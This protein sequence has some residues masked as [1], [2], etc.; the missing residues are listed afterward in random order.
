MTGVVNRYAVGALASERVLPDDRRTRQALR[1]GVW[2]EAVKPYFIGYGDEAL[3]GASPNSPFT[4]LI[5]EGV[6]E[7]TRIEVQRQSSIIERYADDVVLEWLTAAVR[8][9]REIEPN[10]MGYDGFHLFVDKNGYVL[11]DRVWNTAVDVRSRIDRLLL[12]H[13]QE[14]T[15][16][17]DIA[18]LLTAY[19]TGEAAPV[20]TRTPYGT[21]G[22]YA[23]RRLARTEITAAAGRATITANIANPWVDATE[24]KL[25]PSHPKVDICD[26]LA[27]VYAVDNVPSYPAHPHCLCYLIPV[28]RSNPA[29]VTAALREE[30]D[31]AQGRLGLSDADA[32]AARRDVLGEFV[33]ITK[34]YG[35]FNAGWTERALMLGDFTAEILGV[36]V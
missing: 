36:G 7:A 27:G 32:I 26:E 21:V 35:A 25:S 19:L 28:V 29:A 18:E 6:Q 14:G 31:A 4:R 34:L 22:S 30:I 11:S 10:R 16:A 5:A 15:A 12:Y 1:L 23:A 33:D 17:V 3:T 2:R 20:T 24:W 8:T 13:I 9:V